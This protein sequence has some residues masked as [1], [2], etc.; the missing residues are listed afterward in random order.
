VSEPQLRRTG[1]RPGDSGTRDAITEAARARFA[2]HGYDGATIRSIAANAG[3][4]PA[5]VHHFFGTKEQLFIA[6]MHL[7]LEPGPLLRQLLAPGVE[8]LGERLARHF[9]RLMREL[10]DTNPMLAL[11]RSAA[12][13]PQAARMLRE[14]YSRAILE[15]VAAE[16]NVSQPRLRASLCMSQ[17]MGLAVARYIIGLRPLVEADDDTLVAAYAPALQHYLTGELPPGR[18]RGGSRRRSRP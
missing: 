8:G 2:S 14:F 5:L 7:P 15:R 13:H 6:T 11:I 18:A 3:V 12:A 17:I 4:D 1:R 9:V 16:L 10:G